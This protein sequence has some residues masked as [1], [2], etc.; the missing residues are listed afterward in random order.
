[1]QYVTCSSNIIYL[2]PAFVVT[3][4]SFLNRFPS[5]FPIIFTSAMTQCM[6]LLLN[7]QATSYQ[8]LGQTGLGLPH[9]LNYVYSVIV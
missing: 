8:E 6:I 7:L 4:A 3:H 1:M 9:V 5:H 2:I